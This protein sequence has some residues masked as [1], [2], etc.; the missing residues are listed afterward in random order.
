MTKN[1]RMVWQKEG[2]QKVMEILAASKKVEE[3]EVVFDRLLTTREINDVARRFEVLMML[4]KGQSY[5][6]IRLKTGMGPSTVARLS[7]KCGFGFSKVAG[8]P[9]QKIKKEYRSKRTLR[10]K[11]V[12]VAT[13]R[14]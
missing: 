4:E 7:A 9:K 13:L 10:Y 12:P 1:Q 14:K 11:G 5:A 8:L 6:D 2:V 3:V